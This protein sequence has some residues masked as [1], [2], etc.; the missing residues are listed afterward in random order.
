M[1]GEYTCQLC[2]TSSFMVVSVDTRDPSIFL[3]VEHVTENS[4]NRFAFCLSGSLVVED[5]LLRLLSVS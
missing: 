3:E 2:T 4:V 5:G 1:S